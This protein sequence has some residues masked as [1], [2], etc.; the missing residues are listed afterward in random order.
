MY[1]NILLHPPMSMVK[2]YVNFECILN[3]LFEKYNNF[4][5]FKYHLIHML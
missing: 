1:T 5:D 3:I 2:I 4:K